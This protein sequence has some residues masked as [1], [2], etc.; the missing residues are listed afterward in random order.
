VV[1]ITL[2][3]L[4][5]VAESLV[6]KSNL[7]QLSDLYLLDAVIAKIQVLMD[8]GISKPATESAESAK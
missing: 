7:P 5:F 6:P 1:V 4:L 8:E 2:A 3:L